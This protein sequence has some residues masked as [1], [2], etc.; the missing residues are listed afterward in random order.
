M[1]KDLDRIWDARAEQLNARLRDEG[2]PVQVSNLSTIWTVSYTQPSPLQLDVPVLP[3][4]RGP[5]AELGRDGPV[6]LQP[7]YNDA[8][9]AAVADKFVAAARAMEH[10]GFWWSDATLTNKS[11]KRRVLREMLSSLRGR[12]EQPPAAAASEVVS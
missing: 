8:E 5:G 7:D 6:D 1:Y 12:G 10:D 2:L 3:A 11:I 9:F 4:R